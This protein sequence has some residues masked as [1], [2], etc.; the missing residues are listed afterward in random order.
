M[1]ANSGARLSGYQRFVVFAAW[2]GMGFDLM[3]ALLFSFVSP[4]AVP[5]LL[6]LP[7]SSAAAG[8]AETQRAITLWTGVVTSLMLLGWAVGGMIFG[9]LADR[10][11]RSRVVVMTML[12]YALGTGA[13]AL[14][15]NIEMLMLFRFIGAIGIGGEWAAGA[16]LVAESVPEERRVSM[17]T[18]LA[19]SGIAGN[20]LAGFASN[21]L[22]SKIP[23]LAH[24]PDLAWRLVMAFG[25]LPALVAMILR[26]RLK[27]PDQWVRAP[28]AA[29]GRMSDLFTPAL[30]RRTWGG[31]VV[32][33]VTL[34]T[35]WVTVTFLP[36]VASFMAVSAEQRASTILRCMMMFNVGS[37]VGTFLAIPIAARLG[38]RRLYIGSFAASVVLLVAAFGLS[39]PP[40]VRL[41]L[42][43]CVAV[44]LGT[45]TGSLQFYLTE[46]FPVQLRSTG[47]AFCANIGRAATVFGPVAVGF[48]MQRFPVLDVLTA[49]AAVP[50]AGLLLIASGFAVETA[51]EKLADSD[52]ISGT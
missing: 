4:I 43:G 40:P 52:A 28:S 5:I 46:L 47:A 39:W 22:T 3:D 1:V 12:L 2:L 27:E 17:G 11:G 49:V 20:V 50:L 37:L 30:R 15:P 51:G 48:A 24:N 14:A 25:A 31:A 8:A 21:I 38:R 42:I 6:G 13:C 23:P 41:V 9:R 44:P 29:R 32:A 35:L 33:V 19:T 10:I 45:L 36:A 26:R 7:A 18:L 34:V 16:T